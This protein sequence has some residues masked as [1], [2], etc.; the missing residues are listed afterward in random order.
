MFSTQA[1]MDELRRREELPKPRSRIMPCDECAHFVPWT[2]S[3]EAPGDYN[4]CS[5][6]HRLLFRVPKDYEDTNWGF[7]RPGCK[8]RKRLDEIAL[9]K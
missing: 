8:D 9:Q 2:K 4:P 3:D 5:K 7:Y 6:G 1:L